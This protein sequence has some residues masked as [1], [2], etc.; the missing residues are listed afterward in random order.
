MKC[1]ECGSTKVFKFENSNNGYCPVCQKPVALQ[2]ETYSEKIRVFFSYGHDKHADIVNRL[3][4]AIEARSGGRIQVW[5]DHK[6]IPRDA[7]W[8]ERITNGILACQSVLAFLSAYSTRDRG[9]CLDELAIALV[10]KHG[11]IRTVLLEPEK[12]TNPPALVSEYQWGNMSDYPDFAAQGE[13]VFQ[14]YINRQADSIIAMLSSDEIRQYNHEM[15]FLREKLGLPDIAPMSKFDLLIKKP[16]IG[17]KW[18]NDKIEKWVADPSAPRAIVIYGNPGVGKSM[19]A[20]HLQHYNPHAAAAIACD[21]HSD[22]YSTSDKVTLWLVYK[23]ALRLPDYRRWLIRLFT[24]SQFDIGSGR[25]RINNLLTQFFSVG[26]DGKRDRYFIII[27]ALDEARA[28]DFSEYILNFIKE[29]SL[30]APWLR[31]VITAREEPHIIE[32][33]GRF[34][35][36]RFDDNLKNNNL[37]IREYFDYTLKSLIL[38]G[39]SEIGGRSFTAPPSVQPFTEEKFAAF[40]DRLTEASHGVFVYAEKVCENIADDFVNGRITAL[41]EYPL[42]DGIRDLFRDTL[43]RKFNKES[44][45]Y[46]FAPYTMRDFEERFSVPLGM[47]MASPKPL[48]AATLIKL[49]NWNEKQYSS[50]M[51]CFGTVLDEKDGCLTPFHKSFAEWLNTT[52]TLYATPLSD[53]IDHLAES[54]YRLY[55]NGADTLDEFLTVTITQILRLSHYGEYY[56]EVINDDKLIDRMFDTGNEYKKYSR[57]TEAEEVFSELIEIFKEDISADTDIKDFDK[58]KTFY[59]Y[60]ALSRYGGIMEVQSRFVDVGYYYQKVLAITMKLADAYPQNPDYKRDLSVALNNVAGIKQ[61]LNDLSG[62]LS[63]YQE[64]L[65]IRKALAKDYPDNPDYKRDL[66]VSHYKLSRIYTLKKDDENALHC[67]ETAL[68]ISEELCA[69]YPQSIQYLSD[70]SVFL[71]LRALFAEAL[72]DAEKVQACLERKA[73]VDR[74]IAELTGRS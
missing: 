17:R 66:Y 65:D 34:P 57:F 68:A 3:K 37:D 74:K 42:P 19:Y 22:E 44:E 55:Q 67:L 35:S 53:G 16:M 62:A 58:R 31:F 46:P 29:T 2:E 64:S 72:D 69:Q 11:M 7:H 18:L 33:F 27:D 73:E 32:R 13:K 1:A 5:I 71:E 70:L 40:A 4:E 36:I 43:D 28:A 9:V 51:F 21:Y 47:V 39:E 20:A 23:L 48:P 26:I 60:M 59:Y 52:R 41:T 30:H 56:Q 8:R 38:G 10:S 50:F 12:V 24:D 15:R 63:L 45:H 14:E 6:E 54:A 61:A 25:D 49:M